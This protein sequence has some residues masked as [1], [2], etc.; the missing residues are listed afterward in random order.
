[1]N[2]WPNFG[3]NLAIIRVS[4]YFSSGFMKPRKVLFFTP[5]NYVKPLKP[6]KNKWN[7]VTKKK[8]GFLFKTSFL[9]VGLMRE[10]GQCYWKCKRHPEEFLMR[11]KP[12]PLTPY[13]YTL[14]PKKFPVYPLID[15]ICINLTLGILARR[16]SLA[17]REKR[18]YNL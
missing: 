4:I 14:S 10:K 3:R 17:D 15:S 8:R 7:Q 16:G 11:G 18:R 6:L 5:K 12:Q 9:Q 13:P 2:I 1:M